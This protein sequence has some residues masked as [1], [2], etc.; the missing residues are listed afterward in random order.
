MF[1]HLPWTPEAA[2]AGAMGVAMARSE[3]WWRIRW[4]PWCKGLR[5][6]SANVWHIL[7][8]QATESYQRWCSCMAKSWYIMIYDYLVPKACTHAKKHPND[9]NVRMHD[10][11][12]G[13]PSYDEECASIGIGSHVIYISTLVRHYKHSYTLYTF[14][15]TFCRPYIHIICIH[16]SLSIYIYT[17]LHI[18]CS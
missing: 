6:K 8:A 2:T 9:S 5:L 12:Q 17:L 10:F 15:D 18:A 4:S 13:T 11:W 1:W 3:W 16:V 7:S 14:V